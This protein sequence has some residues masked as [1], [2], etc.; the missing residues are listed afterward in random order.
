MS[1]L[2]RLDH[3]QAALQNTD[4]K[5][6]TKITCLIFQRNQPP[7]M[8]MRVLI[9]CCPQ[10]FN[11]LLIICLAVKS[12][13]PSFLPRTF[14]PRPAHWKL[15]K[16]I[17]AKVTTQVLNAISRES[18]VG[19]GEGRLIFI[20]RFQKA[21]HRWHR[22]QRRGLT[23][24]R[25]GAPLC[26]VWGFPLYLVFC[27]CFKFTQSFISSCQ[28]LSARLPIP[29]IANVLWW[30]MAVRF[31]IDRLNLCSFSLLFHVKNRHFVLF[32]Q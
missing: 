3:F 11:F 14:Q 24:V 6:I 9:C 13:G 8:T 5:L 21:N 4:K 19:E 12:S 17:K 29:C 25:C 15:F 18:C 27:F 2:S 32:S 10:M 30:C 16:L 26:A 28:H 23:H 20:I 22:H 7:S 31:Q 1:W